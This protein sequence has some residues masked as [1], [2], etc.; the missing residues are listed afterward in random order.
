MKAL[1]KKAKGCG[2]VEIE[3][4]PIPSYE[5]DEVLIKVAYAGICGTDIHILHDQFAYYP[6]VIMGHEFS[7]EIVEVGSKVTSFKVG[8]RVVAANSAP[9]MECY[10]CRIGEYNLCEHIEFLNGTNSFSLSS[11]IFSK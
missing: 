10:Y 2:F 3:D 5:D 9:C 7:G 6:P 11:T 1:V 8:D 4:R